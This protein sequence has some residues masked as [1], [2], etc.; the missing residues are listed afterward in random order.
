MQHI[1]P[2]DQEHFFMF[3]LPVSLLMHAAVSVIV[4]CILHTT[5]GRE[6]SDILGYSETP[7]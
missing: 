6:S 7:T 1:G 5:R 3:G 4:P 2:C